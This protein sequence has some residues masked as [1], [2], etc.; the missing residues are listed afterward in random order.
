MQYKKEK[1]STGDKA[2]PVEVVKKE[3]L[4]VFMQ[5]WK[6][7]KSYGP[8]ASNNHVTSFRAGQLVFNESEIESFLEQGAPIRV[9]VHDVE[10]TTSGSN[11]TAKS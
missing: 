4:A 11:R 2:L 6:I 9:Y 1:N 8:S 5:H 3:R 10:S 7:V